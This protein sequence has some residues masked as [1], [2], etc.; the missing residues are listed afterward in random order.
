MFWMT[1]KVQE[2]LQQRFQDD[3]PKVKWVLAL[4]PLARL[5][6]AFAM[7]GIFSIMSDLFQIPLLQ[8]YHLY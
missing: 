8:R 6:S 4:Y 3:Y 5:V 7:A 2:D 1:K